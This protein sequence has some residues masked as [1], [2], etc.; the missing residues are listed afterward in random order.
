MQNLDGISFSTTPA[1]TGLTALSC[2]LDNAR[3]PG[4]RCQRQAARPGRTL[5]TMFVSSVVTAVIPVA[6][7]SVIAIYR[8]DHRR[9]CSRGA[10]VVVESSSSSSSSSS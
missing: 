7:S 3:L 2:S 9:I 10:P 4:A 6:T 8:Y 5:M 1:M